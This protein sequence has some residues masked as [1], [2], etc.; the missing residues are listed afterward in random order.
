MKKFLAMFLMM[1][2]LAI[3]APLTANAQT[4]GSRR[5]Y[6]ERTYSTRTYSTRTYRRPDFYRRHRNVI[7]VGIGTGIGAAVGALVGGGRGA[8]I[9]AAA[10]AGGGALYTYKIN[11]KRHR[12]YRR[13]Y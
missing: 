3:I 6:R 9:G 12:Y 5:Y 11:P 4:R 7:N 13:N 1:G 2:M 10:G 8:L